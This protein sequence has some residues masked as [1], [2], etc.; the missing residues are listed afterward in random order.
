VHTNLY[1]SIRDRPAFLRTSPRYTRRMARRFTYRQRM[2]VGTGQILRVARVRPD[3]ADN[4]GIPRH[5]QAVFWLHKSTP[6]KEAHRAGL[7]LTYNRRPRPYVYIRS[8]TSLSIRRVR[9]QVAKYSYCNWLPTGPFENAFYSHVPL[10]PRQ[11]TSC[12]STLITRR[13]CSS[14]LICA[15]W[16]R[17][18]QH[19]PAHRHRENVL[20]S[21]R[22]SDL[23]GRRQRASG[24][25]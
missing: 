19:G 14:L 22:V 7:T 18:A 4:S 1:L 20:G 10:F 6:R 12:S 16:S 3:G 13:E 24:Y 2:I 11:N 9:E 23:I 25:P 21:W 17:A 15:F 8:D 5:Q